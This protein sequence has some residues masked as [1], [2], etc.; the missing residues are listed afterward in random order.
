MTATLARNTTVKGEVY[1]G[2]STPPADVADLLR[3]P[4]YWTGGTVPARS[5]PEPEQP[6]SLSGL[7]PTQIRSALE[8]GTEDVVSAARNNSA[9]LVNTVDRDICS[10]SATLVAGTAYAQA[11]TAPQALAVTKIGFCTAATPASGANSLIRFGLFIVNADLTLT[12]VARTASDL[13]LLQ[14]ADT[15]YR[16]VLATAGGFPASYTLVPGRRYA[17]GLIVVGG[18]AGTL[19]APVAVV[20][21]LTA[22]EP[23]LCATVGS[24]VGDLPTAPT[25]PSG[26]GALRFLSQVASA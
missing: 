10:G 21:A 1:L 25:A 8:V 15:V 20:G 6:I 17:T 11:F 23:R 14:S 26:T 5:V 7:T 2:G 16:K 24:S 19:R 12:L 9:T 4:R 3:N 22:D 18:V 13:T